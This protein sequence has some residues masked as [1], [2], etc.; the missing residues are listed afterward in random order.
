M[1]ERGRPIPSGFVM[2]PP[3]LDDIM[4]TSMKACAEA[5][6][7]LTDLRVRI[8]ENRTDIDFVTSDDPAIATNKWMSQK[9]NAEGFGVMSSGYILIMPLTP[10]LAVLS[11]DN[12]V[13]PRFKATKQRL[14]V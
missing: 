5:Q 7:L 12:R 11:Y 6:P 8:V 4:S 3:T 1:H 14:E 10:R 13:Y 2:P 9:M